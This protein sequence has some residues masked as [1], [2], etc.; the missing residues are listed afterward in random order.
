MYVFA[1]NWLQDEYLN[2][3]VWIKNIKRLYVHIY[4]SINDQKFKKRKTIYWDFTPETADN[5]Y[6]Q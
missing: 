2:F 1:N 6:S 5:A 4:K 3:G